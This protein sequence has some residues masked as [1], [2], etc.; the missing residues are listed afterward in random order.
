MTVCRVLHIFSGADNR[1]AGLGYPAVY[2]GAEP[3]GRT[4]A[5]NAGF[6]FYRCPPVT[7]MIKRSSVPHDIEGRDNDEEEYETHKYLWL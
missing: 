6:R 5:L 2:Y 1:V 7:D 3:L 4:F